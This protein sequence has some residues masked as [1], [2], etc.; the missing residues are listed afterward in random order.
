MQT[1]FDTAADDLV[2][3]K[4][5]FSYAVSLIFFFKFC[6]RVTSLL[7]SLLMRS[8]CGQIAINNY[9]TVLFLTSAITND[10]RLV[11]KYWNYLKLDVELCCAKNNLKN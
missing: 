6:T 1:V 7:V 5:K 3:E 4:I 9:E 10:P 8:S 11:K 2:L